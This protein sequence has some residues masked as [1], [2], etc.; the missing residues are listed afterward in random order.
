MKFRC[1]FRNPKTEARHTVAVS[2]TSD[3]VAKAQAADDPELYAEAFAL[4]HAYR[5]LGTDAAR[6]GMLH[7]PGEVCLLQ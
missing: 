6:A 2:L 5:S 4:R 1:E 7:M 3:E